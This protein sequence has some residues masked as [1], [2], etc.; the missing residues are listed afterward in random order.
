MHHGIVHE[1]DEDL[2]NEN[3]IHGDN[4]NIVGDMDGD[5]NDRAVLPE[6][7]HGTADDFLG[8]L[9]RLGDLR[10]PAHACDGENVLHD[11]AQPLGLRTDVAGERFLLLV[12]ETV[13]VVENGRGGADNGGKGGADVVRYGAQQVGTHL[14]PFHLETNLF[15]LLDLRGHGADHDGYG[16]HDDEGQRVACQREIKFEIRIGEDVVHLEH[17]KK[18]SQYAV[19]IAGGEAGNDDDGQNEDQRHVGVGADEGMEQGTYRAG[20]KE[21]SGG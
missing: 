8:Q 1:I 11:A 4:E 18:R 21:N 7:L 19:G 17:G 14:L 2:F 15:L 16:E 6:F 10:V 5:G 12:V 13:V 9:L 3:R 20:E